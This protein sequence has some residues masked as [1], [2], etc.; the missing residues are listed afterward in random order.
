MKKNRQVS[1]GQIPQ[2]ELRKKVLSVL[3]PLDVKMVFIACS[4]MQEESL[5]SK[6]KEFCQECAK[7]GYTEL[8]VW[9]R[10][11]GCKRAV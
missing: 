7:K 1:L 8:L 6:D 5:L 11:R 9:L 2:R 4:S 3:S 10:E